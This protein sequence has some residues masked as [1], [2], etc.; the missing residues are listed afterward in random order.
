MTWT[1]PEV[2]RP[3]RAVGD[4]A[5]SLTSMLDLQRQTLLWKCGGL[6]AEQLATQ[7]IPGSTLSLLGIV[8]HLTDAEMAWFRERFAGE[9]PE[10][11]Y[12]TEAYPEC[13]FEDLDPAR[14]EQDFEAYAAE[15]D[16]IRTTLANRTLDEEFL[17]P[18]GE[19]LNLRWLYL[20]LIAEYARHNG[21]AD[22]IREQIDGRTGD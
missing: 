14:A 7:P 19:K 11:L 10:Y 21:H 5:T 15:M 18:T 3:D 1:A 13:D 6:T 22:L 17:R 8:R 12:F 16:R 9:Q 2:Q 20:H 4:E